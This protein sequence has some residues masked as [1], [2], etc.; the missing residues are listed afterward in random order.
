MDPNPTVDSSEI[1]HALRGLSHDMGANQIMLE[2]SFRRMKSLVESS[3]TEGTPPEEV[4]LSLRQVEACMRAAKGYLDDLLRLST[5]GA[6]EMEPVPVDVATV[7][8]QVLL[9]Q[10]PLL[11]ERGSKVHCRG[12][13]PVVWCHPDRLKQVLT[14]LVRNA[15]L[16]GCDAAQ[17]QITVRACPAPGGDDSMAALRIHDNGPGIDP[18]RRREI[19]LPGCRIANTEAEGSGWGLPTA[20]R[21]AERFG[22]SLALDTDCASGTA[23]IL[24]LPAATDAVVGHG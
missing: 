14:N 23:F 17:P 8:E 21:I 6:A 18:R 22:G 9:E 2:H 5:S 19:F 16:H 15:A 24:A 1:L 3:R 11:A 7:I 4:N 10:S 20:R 12:D 13:L